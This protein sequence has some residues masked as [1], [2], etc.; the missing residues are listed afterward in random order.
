MSIIRIKNR[1]APRFLRRGNSL[2]AYASEALLTGFTLL[3]ILIAL[4]IFSMIALISTSALHTVINAQTKTEMNAKRLREL[5]TTFILM[6]RE[7]TQAIDR[8]VINSIGKEDVAFKG[9][10]KGFIFTHLG[11]DDPMSRIAR[12]SLERSGYHWHKNKL[13]RISFEALDQAPKAKPDVQVL[14]HHV[15]FAQFSYLDGEGRFHEQWPLAAEPNRTIPRAVK[16]D[17]EI[18][19]WGKVSQTY[20]IFADPLKQQQGPAKSEDASTSNPESA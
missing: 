4:F 1:Y 7:I 12:S 6:S 11:L 2:P 17:L 5:Q 9:T 15:I 18:A 16:I 19:Q 8:P 10:P 14:L 3:E 13:W 20:V